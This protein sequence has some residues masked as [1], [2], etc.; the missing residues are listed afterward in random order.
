MIKK[1]KLNITES[2]NQY[3]IENMKND[4]IIVSKNQMLQIKKRY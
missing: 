2:E 3:S 4:S 1:P